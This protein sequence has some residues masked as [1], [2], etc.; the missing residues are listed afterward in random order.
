[1]SKTFEVTLS[2]R[3]GRTA[4]VVADR[5]QRIE[6][7]VDAYDRDARTKIVQDGGDIT[8]MES[9]YEVRQRY[10]ACYAAEK[11]AR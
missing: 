4:F 6:T 5:V 2:G 10:E 7:P 9:P 8:V 1:M 3:G 11:E